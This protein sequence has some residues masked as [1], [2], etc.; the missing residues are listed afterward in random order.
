MPKQKP[1]NKIPTDQ[2]DLY[3]EENN[4][5]EDFS[6]FLSEVDSRMSGFSKY[7]FASL[8]NSLSYRGSFS[9]VVYLWGPRLA[10]ETQRPPTLLLRGLCT[11]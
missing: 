5:E 4:V 8:T 7:L 1:N 11:I 3:N 2:Y 10:V 9:Q 6:D